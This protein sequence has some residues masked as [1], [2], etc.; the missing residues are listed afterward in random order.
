MALL[1]TDLDVDLSMLHFLS[2]GFQAVMGFLEGVR[3]RSGET[4]IVYHAASGHIHTDIDLSILEHTWTCQQVL[5]SKERT[6][7]FRVQERH[8][9]NSC[10]EQACS[11]D[12]FSNTLDCSCC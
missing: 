7:K 8:Q 12:A 4:C 5:Q 1:A 2:E 6:N 11:A 9:R 10:S 3:I